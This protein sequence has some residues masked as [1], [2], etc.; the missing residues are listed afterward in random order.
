MVIFH[1]YVNVYQEGYGKRMAVAQ[2]ILE[3]LVLKT[4]SIHRD[5]VRMEIWM[6]PK[7][8]T[9]LHF[10][11]VDSCTL[12]EIQLRLNQGYEDGDGMCWQVRHL[13]KM[14]LD[15]TNWKITKFQ[16]DTPTSRGNDPIIC[17]EWSACLFAIWC[18]VE[19]LEYPNWEANC[20]CKVYMSLNVIEA[21]EYGNNSLAMR[22]IS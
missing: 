21:K 9:A 2:L 6:G 16:V 15:G 20:L 5:R 8:A 18:N 1:S 17:R 13:K 3:D 14:F 7:D 12:S 19:L 10:P 22:P 4:G 11:S